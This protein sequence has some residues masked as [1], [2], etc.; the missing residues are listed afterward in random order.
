MKKNIL[1]AVLGLVLLVSAGFA[2]FD[3]VIFSGLP[4]ILGLGLSALVCAY[5]I[6]IPFIY[7][8]DKRFTIA[9]ICFSALILINSV[10]GLL[11][12]NDVISID[13]VVVPFVIILLPFGGLEYFDSYNLLY[14]IV[15]ALCGASTV[16]SAVNLNKIKRTALV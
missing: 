7:K 14:F 9:S 13:F 15:I 12:A 5:L 1:T 16:M 2:N 11:A 6:A 3:S 4:N 8:G 10:L